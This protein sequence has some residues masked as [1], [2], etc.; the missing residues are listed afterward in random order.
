MGPITSVSSQITPPVLA[1]VS[2]QASGFGNFQDLLSASLQ[3]V[4]AQGAQSE[5]AVQQFLSG[6]TDDIHKVA[7]ASQKA[8]LSAQLFMQVRNKMISAYQEIMKM[9]M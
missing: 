9:Q 7:I 4:E 2:G 8:E 3:N 6:E 5:K 1:P